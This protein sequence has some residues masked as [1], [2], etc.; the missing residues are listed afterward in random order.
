MSEGGGPVGTIYSGVI[1]DGVGAT[2]LTHTAG[3]VTFTG[4]NHYSGVTTIL[5]GNIIGANDFALSENSAFRVNSGAGLL[6]ADGVEA[7]IGSLADGPLGGGAVLIGLVDPNTFLTIGVDDSS[8]TFSGIIT[9]V[10][11]LEKTGTGIQTLTGVGS[12]IGGDLVLCDCGGSGGLVIAGGTFDAGGEVDV[13]DSA[14]SVTLGGVLRQLDPNQGMRHRQQHH[15]VSGAGSRV[16]ASGVVQ[17]FDSD[18]SV[19]EGG[20]LSQLDPSPGIVIDESTVR[21][22]GAGS[23]VVAGGGVV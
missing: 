2:A 21:I 20:D 10:G 6:V 8:T 17:M 5:G 19:T 3:D 4:S 9:G 11:S 12:A 16:V 18:L 15:E 22:A 14:L 13:F 23:K 7:A 1:S